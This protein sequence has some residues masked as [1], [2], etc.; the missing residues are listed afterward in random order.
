MIDIKFCLVNAQH[1][2]YLYIIFLRNN[3]NN[4]YNKSNI[5]HNQYELREFSAAIECRIP[6]QFSPD[7]LEEEDRI[8]HESNRRS[9]D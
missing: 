1:R 8:L 7:I 5:R 2:R 9:I 6:G 4:T 3:T